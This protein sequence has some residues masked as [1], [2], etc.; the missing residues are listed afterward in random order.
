[1]TEHPPAGSLRS[2]GELQQV[3]RRR[4]HLARHIEPA[5]TR[6]VGYA[7]WVLGQYSGP[8]RGHPGYF[9]ALPGGTLAHSDDMIQ[10]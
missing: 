5:P 4:S 6:Q 3:F 1:M 8:R 7:L 9:H 10:M 2:F